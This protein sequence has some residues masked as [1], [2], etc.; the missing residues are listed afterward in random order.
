MQDMKD[1]YDEGLLMMCYDSEDDEKVVRIER[2]M[3]HIASEVMCVK[4]LKRWYAVRPEVTRLV[5]LECENCGPG[6]V[7]ETGEQVMEI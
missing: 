4:C 6:Y 7:I 5:D 2:R 3:P 1:F